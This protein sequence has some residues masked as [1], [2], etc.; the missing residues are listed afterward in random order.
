MAKNNAE[1]YGVADKI[2]FVVGDFFTISSMLQADVIFMS[3]PWGGPEYSG[4]N[5]SLSSMCS[6]YSSGGYGIFNIVKNIAPSIAFHM[7]KTT[8]ILEV[9][10]IIYWVLLFITF[11]FF[12]SVYG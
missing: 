7:P 4:Q 11:F 8:N 2:E 10:L 9:S 6:N 12:F 1:I 5:F 3:P